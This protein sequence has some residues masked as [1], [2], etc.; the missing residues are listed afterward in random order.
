[1]LELYFLIF[2]CREATK[3]EHYP[4]HIFIRRKHQGALINLRKVLK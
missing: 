1:M 2:I 4:L 3:N